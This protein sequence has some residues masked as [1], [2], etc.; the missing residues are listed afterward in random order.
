MAGKSSW[1]KAAMSEGDLV[2]DLDNLWEAVSGCD[3]YVKPYKLKPI[4]FKLRDTL[5]DAGSSHAGFPNP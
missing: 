3:R 2:I 5:L 1:V 4:V